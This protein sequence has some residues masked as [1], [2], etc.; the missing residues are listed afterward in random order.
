MYA[1]TVPSLTLPVE[2]VA[3]NST[4]SPGAKAKLQANSY[5]SRSPINNA[6]HIGGKEKFHLLE[7]EA[8]R[9]LLVQ[10]TD[11]KLILL[12]LYEHCYWC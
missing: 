12:S 11:N 1:T 3:E 5:K 2:A 8:Y 10:V 6:V 4:G 7:Y 9:K